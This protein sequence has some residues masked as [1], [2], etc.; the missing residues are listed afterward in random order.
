MPADDHCL[1]LVLS[2]GGS[3]GAYEVGALEVIL[4]DPA[5]RKRGRHK[6]ITG[7][8]VGAIN[9]AWVAM[10]G[11]E[12]GP[13]LVKMWSELDDAQ[14]AKER[15]LSPLSLAWSP[16]LYDTSPLRAYLTARLKP[17]LMQDVELA[18]VAVDLLSGKTAS[19]SQ[20]CSK[21]RM[22]DGLMASS[23]APIFYPRENLEDGAWVD[24]GIYDVVPLRQAIDLGATEID[25]VC[26]VSRRIPPWDGDPDRVW[27]NGPRVLELMLRHMVENDLR[28]CSL[29]NELVHAGRAQHKRHVKI[30]L[31]R[32]LENLPL[33]ARHFDPAGIA[34]LIEIGK[35]DA[36]E[37][38]GI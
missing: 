29:Y 36:R 7:T 33:D 15:F 5:L 3:Q 6:L 38:F 2:G 8:S 37:V 4:G 25:V 18:I 22:L 31:I 20:R 28:A 9:G 11:L 27:G 30:N 24:G 19:W 32:P 34:E 13:E 10:H 16:S 23:A 14:V 26:T 1:A 12:A 21:A 17:S 35:R